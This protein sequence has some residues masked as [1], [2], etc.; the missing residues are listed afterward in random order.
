[1]SLGQRTFFD[2]AAR[3]TVQKLHWST[4]IMEEDN[5]LVE[6]DLPDLP[7]ALDV[8]TY[9]RERHVLLIDNKEFQGARFFGTSGV[10]TFKRR[11]KRTCSPRRCERRSL[12][13]CNTGD[14]LSWRLGRW[15]RTYRPS[16]RRRCSPTLSN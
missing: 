2:E 10:P 16:S 9:T 7:E 5:T 8:A 1:M 6:V 15:K 11:G 3:G 14:G 12:G 4:L 13:D